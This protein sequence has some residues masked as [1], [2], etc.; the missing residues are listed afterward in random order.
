MTIPKFLL[1]A[2]GPFLI[3][4]GLAAQSGGPTP[5]DI[6]RQVDVVLT[7][8]GVSHYGRLLE[9]TDSTVQ[10]GC[11]TRQE[12]C[13][14]AFREFLRKD[15][16]ALRVRRGTR[17]GRGLLIGVGIGAA[18]GAIAG[19]INGPVD[20]LPTAGVAWSLGVVGG[21]AGGLVG[22]DVGR[23]RERW[24]EIPLP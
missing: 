11:R 4:Q 10:L 21:L 5:T 3:P 19:A 13:L 8:H 20:D 12:R 1:L 22:A 6:R 17:M 14:E 7:I 24:V 16:D 23:R 2:M 9:W 18:I 15:L